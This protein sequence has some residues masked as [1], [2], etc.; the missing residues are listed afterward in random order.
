MHMTTL[1][2][3]TSKN[4]WNGM[5]KSSFYSISFDSSILSVTLTFFPNINV[6]DGYC[7]AVGPKKMHLVCSLGE[8]S[9]EPNICSL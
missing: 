2:G 9:N 4:I 8:W 5:L 3:A 6:E 1:K 7:S